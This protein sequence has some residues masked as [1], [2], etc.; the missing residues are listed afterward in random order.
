MCTLSYYPFGVGRFLLVSNR[1]ESLEREPAT[2]PQLRT[3]GGRRLLMPVDPK[4][5]GTWIAISDKARAVCLLNGAFERH[6][7]EP[8]YAKSRGSIVTALFHYDHVEDFAEE[9]P[10]S[11]IGTE[12]LSVEPFTLVVVESDPDLKVYEFRWDG[13]SRYLRELDAG[14]PRVWSSAQLYPS[15]VIK[16]TEE[17]FREFLEAGP[18]VDQSRLRDF[19]Y[20]ERYKE[21]FQGSASE[22]EPVKGLETLSITSV[23]RE[24][25]SFLHVYE[26]LSTGTTVRTSFPLGVH[27]SL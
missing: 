7:N 8:P 22:E 11:G 5:G 13:E 26:D 23:I 18:E 1:D 16:E 9:Y 15:P 17:R 6:L 12:G 14:E 21:K 24:K 2:L 19:N 3:V 10:L 4:G 27:T 25:H 20:R